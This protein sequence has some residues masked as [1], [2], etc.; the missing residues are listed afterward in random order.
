MERKAA[1]MSNLL[2][3]SRRSRPQIPTLTII[4]ELQRIRL[5]SLATICVATV[6]VA[7]EFA[8]ELPTFG[9]YSTVA[10]VFLNL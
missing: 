8:D 4:E 9:C 3:F 1:L 6:T 2:M 7:T 10:A 5:G